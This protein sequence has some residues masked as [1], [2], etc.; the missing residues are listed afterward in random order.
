M[1]WLLDHEAKLLSMEFRGLA[2][3]PFTLFGFNSDRYFCH[4]K[5]MI[6]PKGSHLSR[7]LLSLLNR[8]EETLAGRLRKHK[9]TSKDDILSLSWMKFSL[10]LLSETHKDIQSLIIELEL[11]V[12]DWDEKWIHVYLDYSIKLLD[13]CNAF[14]SKLSQLNQGQLLLRFGLH[15]LDSCGSIELTKASSSFDSWRQ[16]IGL[17]NLRIENCRPILDNLV[18]LLNLPEVKNSP[19]G[20][21]LMPALYGVRVETIFVCSVFTAAFTGSSSKL[22]DLHVP[23]THQWADAYADLQTTVN[24]QIRNLVPRRSNILVKELEAVDASIMDLCPVL[25]DGLDS[26]EDEARRNSIAELRRRTETLSGELDLLAKEVD[27]FSKVVLD[28]RDALIFYL[29]RCINASGSP[30]EHKAEKQ[31]A[32]PKRVMGFLLR[33]F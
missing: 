26:V 29:K 8:F 9:P 27:G 30:K 15:K 11:P 31:M 22:I 23:K 19:K 20:K 12:C 32:S 17:E 7:K 28:G 4:Y 3:L 16:H 18:E 33:S 13:I 2:A 14:I 1:V 25:K 21:V 5:E 10:Q 24:E 6:Y